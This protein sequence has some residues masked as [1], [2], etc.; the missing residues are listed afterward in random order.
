MYGVDLHPV[1]V[2]NVL[3]C[4][5]HKTGFL[6]KLW[7][8]YMIFIWPFFMRYPKIPKISDTQKFPLIT[9]KFE[10]DGYTLV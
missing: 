5:L 6:I 7:E 4:L 2:S 10:H 8:I 1:T 9:L 3:P